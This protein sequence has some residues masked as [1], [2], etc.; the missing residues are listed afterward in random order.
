MKK[1]MVGMAMAAVMLGCK[2][3]K[4]APSTT[5]TTPKEASTIVADKHAPEPVE[6]A[7]EPEAKPPAEPTKPVVADTE[8]AEIKEVEAD[9]ETETNCTIS[10]PQATIAIDL[11][12]E[13]LVAGE[14]SVAWEKGA[15]HTLAIKTPFSD[16]ENAGVFLAQVK[17]VDAGR[18]VSVLVSCSEGEDIFSSDYV[19]TLVAVGTATTPPTALWSGKGAY[20]SE[21]EDCEKLDSVEF[22]AGA[23]SKIRVLRK[24]GTL[25]EDAE[26]VPDCKAVPVVTTEEGLVAIP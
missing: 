24:K 6:E 12:E 22:E 25:V 15:T 9:C 20:S 8:P 14:L 1:L 21:M 16:C 17:G 5:D 10:I 7:K 13:K 11:A 26:E 23:D 2:S 3:E 4:K 19:A 18:V